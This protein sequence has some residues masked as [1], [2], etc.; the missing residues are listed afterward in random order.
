[1]ADSLRVDPAL[2][3]QAADGFRSAVAEVQGP[4]GRS[5]EHGAGAQQR[6]A[7][8]RGHGS[9][10]SGTNSIR[11]SRGTP[12]RAAPSSRNRAIARRPTGP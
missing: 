6:V 7:P 3:K 11:S 1:M 10:S 5:V 8:G 4:S 2:V 9:P 12:A